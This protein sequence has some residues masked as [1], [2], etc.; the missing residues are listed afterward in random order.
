M[1]AR[2]K[3]DQADPEKE[4]KG[5]GGGNF[6]VFILPQFDFSK[7]NTA[8]TVCQEE[9]GSEI[10]RLY[11]HPCYLYLFI[12][13]FFLLTSGNLLCAVV[14]RLTLAC[15]SACSSAFCRASAQKDTPVLYAV[16]VF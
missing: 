5:S 9:K 12:Y 15:F 7:R 14:I 1:F 2:E 6:Y 4:R 3:T 13:L 11:N 8:K 10:S 16:T